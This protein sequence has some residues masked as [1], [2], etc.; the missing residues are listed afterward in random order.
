[1]EKENQIAFK[2]WAAIVSALSEGKQ[3]LIVRKGGIREEGDE[4][5]IEHNEFFLFP[6]FEHQKFEDLKTEARSY[7]ERAISEK[8]KSN[9]IPVRYYAEVKSAIQLTDE[10]DISRLDP[11]HVWSEKAM[12]QRFHFGKN[13][14]FF[15][16]AVR[17]YRLLET[18]LIP[19]QSEYGG[20]KSWVQFN[21]KIK[22]AGALP[23]VSDSAF[24]SQLGNI[25][26]L[27][28]KLPII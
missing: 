7:L 23:V 13:K 8:P 28:K 2:E 1:M 6:T 9:Q 3:I 10:R 17:I 21:S 25:Q 12:T 27:F 20:C 16:L 19:F 24:Q 22:T 14:G 5:Q 11:F 15:V 4:F 18:T 26:S